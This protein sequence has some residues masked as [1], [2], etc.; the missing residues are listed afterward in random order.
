[1][2]QLMSLTE[3]MIKLILGAF[4]GVVSIQLLT[5]K[6]N[7]NYL[8]YGNHA[9]GR[10]YF[11]PGRVQLLVITIGVAF[12]YLFSVLK[13]P[14]RASMPDVDASVLGVLF[15]SHVVYLSGKARALL[16]SSLRKVG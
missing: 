13:T 8:L 11:S 2:P 7:S 10:R 16:F 9:S 15:G 5:G 14:N 3:F 4:A 12:N 6:I 1:M